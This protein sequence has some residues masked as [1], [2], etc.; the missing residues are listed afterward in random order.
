MRATVEAVQPYE[1]HGV[2]YFRVIYRGEGEEG[3]REARVS[4]DMVYADPQ[5]GDTI[6]VRAILGV[7]DRIEKVDAGA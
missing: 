5:Q 6:E 7:V 4:Y 3:F 2:R 1:L